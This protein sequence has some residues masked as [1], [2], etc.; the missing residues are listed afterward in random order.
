M[1]WHALA[2]YRGA[3][4][5]AL[6]LVVKERSY[7]LA[8]SLRLRPSEPIR[9][10]LARG[11][12]DA[13]DEW[14]AIST[15]LA[16]LAEQVGSAKLELPVIE[17]GVCRVQPFSPR[18]IYAAASNYIEHANE[19]GTQLAAKAE[20]APYV[21]MKASTS[22]IGPD[23]PVVIPKHSNQVDWEVELA[24]VIGKGGRDIPVGRALEHV[25]AYT[26]MN[27]VSSRDLTRRSDYPFKFDWFRGK[28]FDTFGPLGPW[29]VPSSCI[30]NPQ[31]LDLA[32]EVNGESMQKDNTSN[33]IWTVA[34]QIAYLSSILTLEPG[35]V[36]ATG[37]PDGVGMGMGRY[38]KP[39]DVMIASVE[40]IGSLRNPVVSAGEGS[41]R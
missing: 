41:P 29:L 13:F 30:P 40:K 14:P 38:L 25:A 21:F 32:L 37:T 18:K 11:L 26:I 28:S 12:P 6:A 33:M 10:L 27:D 24:A 19:M 15:D 7:D 20:S 34:E 8:A 16:Q 39:G 31:A 23:Q 5:N 3:E 35:D 9:R 17:A 36:I 4:G 2:T 22:V 1:I